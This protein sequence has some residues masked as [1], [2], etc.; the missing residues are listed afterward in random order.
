MVEAAYM[1][2]DGHGELKSP[3]LLGSWCD[4]SRLLVHTFALK[5]GEGSHD[6]GTARLWGAMMP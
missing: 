3:L 6:L 4:R 2:R 5:I 1:T